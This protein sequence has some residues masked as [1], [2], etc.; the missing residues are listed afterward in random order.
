MKQKTSMVTTGITSLFLIFVVLSLAILSLLSLGNSRADRAMSVQSLQATV[1]YYHA[2]SK[3]AD[4][5]AAIERIILDNSDTKDYDKIVNEIKSTY[6]DV[7]FEEKSNELTSVFPISD[8]LQLE[9]I[10]KLISD[11]SNNNAGEIQAELIS[12]RSIPAGEW[13]PDLSQNLLVR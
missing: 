9:M 6:P 4:F 11:D 13:N 12:L 8:D 5:R 10:L 3:S 7:L 2:K 1:E